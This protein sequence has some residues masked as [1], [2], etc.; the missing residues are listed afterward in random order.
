MAK[1]SKDQKA[2]VVL[3]VLKTP[4]KAERG[5]GSTVAIVQGAS[6]KCRLYGRTILTA[7]GLI[8]PESKGFAADAL[9]ECLGVP[10]VVGREAAVAFIDK[11]K[12]VL[13][14]GNKILDADAKGKSGW[15]R[16]P[17]TF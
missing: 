6:G 15:G 17:I 11:H 10:C 4:V 14:S 8:G 7:L 13:D 9:A 2:L 12:L 3:A 5:T 1:E 16:R